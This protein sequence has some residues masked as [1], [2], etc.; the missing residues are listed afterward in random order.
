MIKIDNLTLEFVNF[1]PNIS[2]K[3]KDYDMQNGDTIRYVYG[4]NIISLNCQGMIDKTTLNA[5][6]AILETD[7][8]IVEY[9]LNGTHT[10]YMLADNFTY[11]KIAV[12]SNSEYWNVSFTL[13]ECRRAT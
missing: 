5:L 11:N 4:K 13:K 2:S 7:E 6:L 9:Q 10:A 1:T 3:A 12:L 8:H